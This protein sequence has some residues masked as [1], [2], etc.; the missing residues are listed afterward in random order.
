[1][2]LSRLIMPF[3]ICSI[4]IATYAQDNAVNVLINKYSDIDGFSVVKI[5]GDMIKMLSESD[6]AEEE[7]QDAMDG[8]SNI[9]ILS[10]E[11]DDLNE[12]INFYTEIGDKI[13]WDNYIEIMSIKDSDMR[14]KMVIRKNDEGISEFLML[15]G[16]EDN[17]LISITGSVDL[18]NIS[19]ISDSV[20]ELIEAEVDINY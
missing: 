15:G 16:G 10:V 13:P 7:L 3:V 9:V 18:Q 2:K 8:L 6:A 19:K 17:F 12:E 11:D 20:D 14:I 5:S 1:M 4:G